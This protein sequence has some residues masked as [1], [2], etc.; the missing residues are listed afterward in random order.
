MTNR[1][2]SDD[3]RDGP[4]QGNAPTSREDGA[5]APTGD[6][7]RRVTRGRGDAQHSATPPP[8][9]AGRGARAGLRA[10][11]TALDG[12]QP[13]TAQTVGVQPP[14]VG[15]DLGS[16][17]V[18]SP[19]TGAQVGQVDNVQPLAP[20]VLV[21]DVQPSAPSG[22]GPGTPLSSDSGPVGGA[23]PASPAAG[24]IGP[25]GTVGDVQPSAPG[26]TAS[27][28]APPPTRADA[29]SVRQQQARTIA[30]LQR[31]NAELRERGR[32]ETLGTP[33]E[34]SRLATPRAL[35]FAATPARSAPVTQGRRHDGKEPIYLMVFEEQTRNTPLRRDKGISISSTTPTFRRSKPAT[36][37]HEPV[38]FL[39]ALAMWLATAAHPSLWG[40]L[41]VQTVGQAT[42][43]KMHNVLAR[44]GG[45]MACVSPTWTQFCEALLFSANIDGRK[46]AAMQELLSATPAAGEQVTEFL[47]RIYAI[48]SAQ[49][50]M[51]VH[52]DDD[53]AHTNT[54]A[55]LQRMA[56]GDSPQCAEFA[57]TI[58]AHKRQG[59]ASNWAAC[60][61]LQDVVDAAAT[62]TSSQGL[63][64]TSASRPSGET[65]T[66]SARAGK[67]PGDPAADDGHDTSWE[68]RRRQMGERR[69]FACGKPGHRAADCRAGRGE[70]GDG[71][72]RHRL[73]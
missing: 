3:A 1:T 18:A 53:A 55:L 66:A 48:A 62:W 30:R 35:A 10:E 65:D 39:T 54:V 7:A 33:E 73:E 29:S 68:E 67:R 38:A 28:G 12:V 40:Q 50:Q 69:C 2:G 63:Y 23:V 25:E 59:M 9:G 14:A 19:S 4:A 26:P 6:A 64:A 41:A 15:E 27:E 20:Y 21:D 49:A 34:D 17:P 51:D 11:P 5:P 58:L 42:V 57:E 37:V 71:G 46:Q 47:D 61:S 43:T 13:S 36:D 44:Y 22:E 16:G 56:A 31:E 8:A 32:G 60:Q 70:G 52:A 72:H 45:P 24:Q